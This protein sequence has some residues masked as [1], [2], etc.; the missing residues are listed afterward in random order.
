MGS[1]V[2]A[3]PLSW[4]NICCVLNAIR[5]ASSVGSDSASSMEFVWTDCAPPRTAA[6]AW[7]VTLTTL[8][9]G[10]WAVS[11]TPD[12]WTWNRSVLEEVFLA[13]NLSF[14]SFIQI[15]LAA[16]NLASSSKKSLW[17][18]KKNESWDAKSSISMFLDN[19]AFTYSMALANVNANSWMAVEPASLMWYPLMLIAFHLFMF[20]E[21]YSN[22]SVISLTLSIG[23]NM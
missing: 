1:I 3:T 5:T 23:G 16:L 17:D 19:A 13:L 7:R 4:A 18:A 20:L 12:V 15:L 9:S 8:P 14:M 22:R 11:V 10:C 21:Q 2:F 6:K